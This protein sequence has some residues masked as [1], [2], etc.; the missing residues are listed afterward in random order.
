MISED[1]SEYT[2]S[3]HIQQRNAT[4][5]RAL[6]EIVRSTL[7]PNGMDK[8]IV[9]ERGE[10]T[11][12]DDGSTV[13]NE[14][15]FEN[16]FAGLVSTVGQSQQAEAGDGTT[17][18]I[19]FATELLSGIETLLDQGVH[20]TSIVDG[21][22][23][24]SEISRET[25]GDLTR[26]LDSV[27][28]HLLQRA[29]ANRLTGIVFGD[30]KT[31]LAGEITSLVEE[32]VATAPGRYADRIA[33]ESDPGRWI[34]DFERVPGATVDKKPLRQRMPTDFEEA[35]I[36]LVDEPLEVDESGH[37]P[38]VTV[39]SFGQYDQH[40]D[41]EERSRATVA[42]RVVASGADVVFCQ[43]RVDDGIANR[44]ADEGILATEFTIKPDLEFLARL[45][46]I[47]ITGDVAGVSEDDLGR[48]SVRQ[49]DD[50][51]RF[52]IEPPVSD[53]TAMTLMLQG[54]TERVAG[55]LEDRV[56]EA[57]D[58]A[59]EL[60]TERRVV[61]GAGATEIAISRR[62]RE[63]ATRK[64]NRQ[65]IVMEAYA[66][67]LEVVPRVL[68][69]NA[70][71]DPLDTLTELRAAHANGDSTA[72]V[73]IVQGGT[74]DVYERG[75]VDFPGTKVAAIT[76]G[77]EAANIVVHVDDIVPATDLPNENGGE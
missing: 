71:L 57:V 2:G 63:A 56:T 21:F 16:P 12:T 64:A 70:G 7:G 53:P 28:E 8:M 39:D 13:V 75:I 9:S 44:L 29:V 17:T 62:V 61:P 14:L 43:K 68:A 73:D 40:V 36:L 49:N 32:I 51:N 66:D 20:P 59:V 42:D 34:G 67:A 6:G 65:Q 52:Y 47:R 19:T 74:T 24:A 60:V 27:D 50:E 15:A 69:E 10:V 76:N 3:K 54:S 45:L 18:A 11:L 26:D 31:A 1:A 77:T 37:E 41:R 5:A 25:I 23:A 35:A 38:A 46:D 4:A 48:A 22:R 58:A 33:V 30:T 55:K 72:G